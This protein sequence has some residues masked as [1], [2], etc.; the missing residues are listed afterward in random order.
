M[1]E[2]PR[3]GHAGQVD[4]SHLYCEHRLDLIARL[5]AIHCSQDEINVGLVRVPALSCDIRNLFEETF[6]KS[7]AGGAQA[8]M[9][10]MLPV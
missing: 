8:F 5:Y 10:L 3:K 1:G 7:G 6:R 2:P 9:R 4:G